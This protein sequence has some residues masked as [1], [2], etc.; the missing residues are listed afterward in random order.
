MIPANYTSFAN[1]VLRIK[2]VPSRF[3]DYNNVE[4]DW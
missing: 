3:S 1:N 2:I 4:F